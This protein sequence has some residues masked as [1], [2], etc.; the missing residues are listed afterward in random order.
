MNLKICS[1]CGKT[2]HL[3]GFYFRKRGPRAGEYYEKCK[4]CMKLRGRRYYHENRERQLSLALTRRHKYRLLVRN[5]LIKVK[6]RPCRDCNVKYP[7]YVMDF[8]H[9]KRE[10]KILDVARMAAAGWSFDKIRREVEKCDVVCANCH[11]IRTFGKLAGIA[12]VV[13]AGL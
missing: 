8:D 11:R 10:L 12:K 3:Q 6:A 7:Y 5:Y 1:K 2:K 13:T 9:R 4:V